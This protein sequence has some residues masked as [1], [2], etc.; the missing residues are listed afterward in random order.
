M[1]GRILYVATDRDDAERLRGEVGQNSI[2]LAE[3]LLNG[4]P[5]ENCSEV[6]LIAGPDARK[7]KAVLERLSAKLH[8]ISVVFEHDCLEADIPFAETQ[9]ESDPDWL[10]HGWLAAG[11]TTL[12]IGDPGVGKTMAVCDLL[13]RFS[14]GH[15]MPDGDH[16]VTEP[17]S[18]LFVSYDD[19]VEDVIN[20]R[21]RAA[22]VAPRSVRWMKGM[23]TISGQGKRRRFRIEDLE[24]LGEKVDQIHASSDERI[25]ILVLDPLGALMNGRNSNKIED[26]YAVFDP[27][28]DFAAPR[29][30]V[31]I[32]LHHAGK[33]DQTKAIN[34]AMGSQGIAGAARCMV[35]IQEDPDDRTRRLWLCAKQSQ[36]EIPDGLSYTIERSEIN[37]SA[38]CEWGRDPVLY[39]AQTWKDSRESDESTSRQL[40]AARFLLGL[41]KKGTRSAVEIES[42]ADEEGIKKRT[43]DSVKG[44]LGIRSSKSPTEG[45]KWVFPG[46]LPGEELMLHT[47]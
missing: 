9:G 42:L 20:P 45:W 41:S 18:S 3:D 14:N 7:A 28:A 10:W 21:L 25:R 34:Q 44:K 40:D 36:T 26:V 38:R 33:S 23:R 16:R 1:P 47:G 31:P 35:H 43:L 29:G 5:P 30:I 19:A 39:T 46:D 12:I 6:R 37:T 13:A 4:S 27:L 11:K 22:G 15:A 8:P 2:P 17:I 24:A 32:V